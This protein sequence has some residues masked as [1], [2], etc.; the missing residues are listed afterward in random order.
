[1]ILGARIR[2]LTELVLCARVVPRRFAPGSDGPRW[3]ALRPAR[4]FPTSCADSRVTEAVRRLARASMGI[5]ASPVLNWRRTRS[6]PIRR[7]R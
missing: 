3:P 5:H 7:R 1:M 4:V 6:C 2:A